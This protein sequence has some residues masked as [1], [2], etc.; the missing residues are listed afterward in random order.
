MTV[1]P[2][3]IVEDDPGILGFMQEALADAG[4]AVVMWMSARGAQEMLVAAHPAAV[5]LDIGLERP[6]AGMEVLR[7][8][9]EQAETAAVPVLVCTADRDFLQEQH[10][11]LRGMGC[12]TLAK[13][14]LVAELVAAVADLVGAG[15]AISSV[16]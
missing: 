11:E 9:R 7:T 1:A 3:A 16:A 5:V 14:F 12:E 10:A 8:M 4:Y 13:P 15:E 6:R 2:I